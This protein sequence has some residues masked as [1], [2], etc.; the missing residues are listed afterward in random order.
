MGFDLGFLINSGSGSTCHV[1]GVAS[2]SR[3]LP[4]CSVR[5]CFTS[6]LATPPIS[7][8][9]K[10]CV[11]SIYLPNTAVGVAEPSLLLGELA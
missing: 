7:K 4:R 9:G 6:S 5:Q 2:P 8:S 10:L 11:L 1:V 3:C